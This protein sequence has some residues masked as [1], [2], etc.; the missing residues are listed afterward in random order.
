[1]KLK[2]Q[3]F[4]VTGAS[5][6]IGEALSKELAKAG[7]NLVIGARNKTALEIVRDEIKDFGVEAVAVAG[8]SADDGVAQQLVKAAKVLGNFAGFIHNAGILHPGPLVYELAE[9]SY[10]EILESN[11]K[12]G[13]QVARYAY[14]NLLRQKEG[15]AVFVGSGIADNHIAGT[16]IYGVAKVAEEYMARQMAL[17]TPEITCFVYRPGVVETDMQKQLREAEGSGAST[18]RPIFK[19]YKDQG[20]VIT[21]EQSAKALVRILE[22]DPRRYHGK[23]ATNRDL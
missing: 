13:Y 22:N 2:G 11:L 9:I 19:G 12:G 14:P 17:E 18:V 16:G 8:S 7:A 1:M 3:T 5:R 6:G 23:I 15:V 4:I 21:A 10:D 20:H